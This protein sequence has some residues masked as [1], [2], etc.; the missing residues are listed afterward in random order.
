MRIALAILMI[1]SSARAA[2]LTGI[3]VDPNATLILHAVV[4][5]DSGASKY[6]VQTDVSGA[7]RFSNLMAGEY[8]LRFSTRGFRTRTI[9]SVVLSEKE[10]KRIPDVTLT[11]GSS[12]D[13][14]TRDLVELPSEVLFGQLSGSVTPAV[15]NVEVTLVCRTFHAC[16]STKT[17]SNGHFS[18]EMISAG[19][20]G[21]NFRHDGFY[22]VNATGYAYTVDDGW[23]SLYSPTFLEECPKG[24]CTVKRRPQ[25][26]VPRCE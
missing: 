4:E 3:V 9:K 17:D 23:E 6:Q 11:T 16:A 15:A 18:F 5:L 12:C 14:S 26:G 10:E 19:V 7:Y 2:S 24:D 22:P 8:T 21:L 20:Y 25:P 13:P 1:S